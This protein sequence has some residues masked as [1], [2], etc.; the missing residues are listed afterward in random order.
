MEN[1]YRLRRADLPALANGG[2]ISREDAADMSEA[3]EIVAKALAEAEETKRASVAAYEAEM[4]RGYEEGREQA[5]RE[6]AEQLLAEGKSLSD[7]LGRIEGEMVSLVQSCLR[8]IIGDLDD[9]TLVQKTVQNALTA[10]RSERRAKLFVSVEALPEAQIAVDDALKEFP[11]T[12][13][14]EVIEDPALR[15]PNLRLES[16]LGVVQ[17]VLDDTLNDLRTM[18][19]AQK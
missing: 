10:V 1:A 2:I 13:Y 15:S 5:A 6:F 17:F 8:Q 11:A 12:E 3:S 14:I 19:T 9:A 16:D 4:A 7:G 18:L